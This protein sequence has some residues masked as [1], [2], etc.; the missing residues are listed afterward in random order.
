[1]MVRLPFAFLVGLLIYISA[2]YEGG[3]SLLFQP[4]IGSVMTVCALL[5]VIVVGSPL[6]L[7]P[8]WRTWSRVGWYTVIVPILGILAVCASWHPAVGVHVY[9]EELETMVVVNHPV[10]W[11]IGCVVTMLGITFCPV[12]GFGEDDDRRWF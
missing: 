4:I 1:M 3:L 8:V 7:T 12:F 6:L 11:A 10:I 2:V 5:G 9:D